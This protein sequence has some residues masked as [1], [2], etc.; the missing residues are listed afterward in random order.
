MRVPEHGG[1]GL[2]RR[3]RAV[4]PGGAGPPQRRQRLLP[5]R[6]AEDPVRDQARLRRRHVHPLMVRIT[7]PLSLSLPLWTFSLMSNV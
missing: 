7:S 4:P 5:A 6:D 1:A 3:G 2:R